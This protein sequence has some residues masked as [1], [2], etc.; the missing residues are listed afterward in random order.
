M[1]EFT[2]IEILSTLIYF[3]CIILMSY[4]LVFIP[5][6]NL[7]NKNEYSLTRNQIKIG[8]SIIG[9]SFI[10]GIYLSIFTAFSILWIAP[11]I[12]LYALLEHDN[13]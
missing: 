11:L 1:E 7:E 8:Y 13:L 3:F 5:L 9:I 12:M 6:R 10:I 4:I 2:S